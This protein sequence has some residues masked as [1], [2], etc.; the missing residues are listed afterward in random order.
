MSD[1]KG[2][3]PDHAYSSHHGR[4]RQMHAHVHGTTRGHARKTA[5]YDSIEG[6]I[7][8][9]LGTGDE[10]GRTM[11]RSLGVDPAVTVQIVN[12]TLADFKLTREIFLLPEIKKDFVDL[13]LGDDAHH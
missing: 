6:M 13:D 1:N 8:G 5:L 4:V 11:G 9:S 3:A 7:A 10:A 2:K 12:A